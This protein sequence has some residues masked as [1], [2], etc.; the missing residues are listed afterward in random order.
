MTMSTHLHEEDIK[1][2]YPMA[3]PYNKILTGAQKH[4]KH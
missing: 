1:T 2:G 4:R 3:G